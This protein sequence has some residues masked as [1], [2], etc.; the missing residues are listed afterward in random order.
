MA[1]RVRGNDGK[2]ARGVDRTVA[3]VGRVTVFRFRHSNSR[4][5]CRP[6]EGRGPFAATGRREWTLACAGVTILEEAAA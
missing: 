3:E 6:G 4:E 5:D 1:S 2:K